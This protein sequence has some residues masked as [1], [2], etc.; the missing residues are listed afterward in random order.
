MQVTLLSKFEQKNYTMVKP[1]NKK[2]IFSTINIIFIA[3]LFLFYH[4]STIAQIP[5]GYG[6]HALST[7][8]IEYD[9]NT[10]NITAHI[11]LKDQ[12]SSDFSVVIEIAWFDKKNKPID[13]LDNDFVYLID[14][15]QNLNKFCSN[16]GKSLK[17][18]RKKVQNKFNF[19]SS[20]VL[21][22]KAEFVIGQLN[23]GL[24]TEKSKPLKVKMDDYYSS[25]ISLELIIYYGRIKKDELIILDNSGTL[26][27]EFMLPERRTTEGLSCEELIREYTNKFNNIKSL[28]KPLTRLE[29]RF[30]RYQSSESSIEEWQEL[31]RLVN[32]FENSIRQSKGLLRQIQMD[33]DTIICI[34]LTD[35]S[36]EIKTYLTNEEQAENLFEDIM[37]AIKELNNGSPIQ[38]AEIP[39]TPLM[40]K[41]NFIKIDRYYKAL[42]SIANQDQGSDISDQALYKAYNDSIKSVKELQ[43]TMIIK[44]GNASEKPLIAKYIRDFENIYTNC[45]KDFKVSESE[46]EVAA[47]TETSESI[48]KPA[49]KRRIPIMW[50][51]I[52]IIMIIIISLGVFKFFPHIKKALNIKGKFKGKIK[53]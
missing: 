40:F 8:K 21:K 24:I 19:P 1:I 12:Y 37:K 9:K 13:G 28:T 30:D 35:L 2:R 6:D 32:E 17:D 44:A 49:K 16:N 18:E 33:K 7:Q 3:C 51:I 52:P 43:D 5:I 42:W 34:G 14:N 47:V 11:L 41:D 25:S 53:R 39:I 10:A 38:N 26:K 31:A 20:I 46:I 48:Q 4:I 36:E 27:W 29:G 15:N 23:D 22:P 45:I 50:I